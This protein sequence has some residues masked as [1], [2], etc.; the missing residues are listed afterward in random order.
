MSADPSQKYP[1]TCL[2]AEGDG[3]VD[4][5]KDEH[6]R[7]IKVVGDEYARCRPGKRPGQT[8]R[9]RRGTLSGSSS[10]CSLHQHRHSRCNNRNLQILVRRLYRLTP[11]K[12]TSGNA[13]GMPTRS[14]RSAA[15]RRKKT[16]NCSRRDERN[17]GA[18]A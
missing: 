2:V 5:C 4:L 17:V 7:R 12:L 18:R 11:S 6:G 10:S 3:Q 14:N 1:S 13:E 8:C 9:S 15:Y 16:K